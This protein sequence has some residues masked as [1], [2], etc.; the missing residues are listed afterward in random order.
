MAKAVWKSFAE[1][2][3]AA[4]PVIEFLEKIRDTLDPVVAILEAIQDLLNL[5]A[6]FLIAIDSALEAI[7]KTI[8]QQIKEFVNDIINNAIAVC[9]HININWDDSWTWKPK[10]LM[11]SNVT[12][13]GNSERNPNF[14]VDSQLPWTANG[15]HGW[16]A[17]ILGSSMSPSNDPH[18]PVTDGDTPVFAFIYVIGVPSFSEF[19]DLLPNIRSLLEAFGWGKLDKFGPEARE[20]FTS[21]YGKSYH[22]LKDCSFVDHYSMEQYDKDY[23]KRILDDITNFDF[24]LLAETKGDFFNSLPKWNRI[25]VSDF[26][27]DEVKKFFKFLDELADTLLGLT[28]L[29]PLA[30]L[31]K[32]LAKKIE[33]LT[34]LL[35]QIQDIIDAIILLL[36]ALST[37]KFITLKT[38]S[39]G[40]AEVVKQA[41]EADNILDVG[42]DGIVAGVCAIATADTG[43][44]QIE[45]LTTMLGA[46]ADAIRAEATEFR[47]NVKEICTE[48]QT[49]ASEDF[50][51]IWSDPEIKSVIP[52]FGGEINSSHITTGVTI[53]IKTDSVEDGQ[54]VE[55]S[56][57]NVIYNTVINNHE[58]IF[59]IGPSD[60]AAMTDG[61]TYSIN[62][63]VS[64]QGGG[65]ASNSDTTFIVNL[66]N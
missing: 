55:L 51:V 50:A 27:G 19:E 7:V 13:T 26:L 30:K 21:N 59:S 41:L 22:K 5:I 58:A 11:K 9:L 66:D 48:I 17:D 49:T 36:K 53:T 24:N 15:M 2:E 1:L 62:V 34:A 37:G 44:D 20:F 23:G 29:S 18:R 39:G 31:L 45:K 56:M 60:L 6:D 65:T 52:S 61:Q 42:S 46:Q 8:V 57:N 12:S 4:E 35:E 63:G 33:K 14:T 16:L 54:D 38:E 32:I 28:D 3:D 64:N 10:E 25:A 40:M 43:L 47:E